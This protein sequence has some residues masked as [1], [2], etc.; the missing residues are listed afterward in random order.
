MACYGSDMECL[1]IRNT[2]W[3][4]AFANYI[5]PTSLLEPRV[6]SAQCIKMPL[7]I[8]RVEYYTQLLGTCKF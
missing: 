8:D 7:C 2:L 1:L 5:E 4:V 6:H 3:R